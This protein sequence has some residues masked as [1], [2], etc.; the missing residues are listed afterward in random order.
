[1]TAVLVVGAGLGLGWRDWPSR[2]LGQS[3]SMNGRLE[4]AFHVLTANSEHAILPL[5]R[6]VDF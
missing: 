4:L 1:M 5:T 6:K 3:A 2:E